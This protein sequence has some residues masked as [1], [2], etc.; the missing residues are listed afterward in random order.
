M[1]WR[2]IKKKHPSPPS[3]SSGGEASGRLHQQLRH[4]TSQITVLRTDRRSQLQG[5]LHMASILPLYVL[6]LI[7]I[8]LR[9]T[10]THL[11]RS[12]LRT[13]I[14]TIPLVPCYFSIW[15]QWYKK[16]KQ[17]QKVLLH[18]ICEAS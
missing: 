16:K 15:E 13:Q 10:G 1:A 12:A 18:F 14:P 9:P 3:L 2:E 5:V 4:L 11:C 7:F 17:K 8:A 6:P